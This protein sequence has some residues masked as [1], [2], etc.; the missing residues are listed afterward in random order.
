VRFLR[1]LGKVNGVHFGKKLALLIDDLGMFINQENERGVEIALTTCL[2][3]ERESCLRSK[4]EYRGIE[5]E[6]IRNIIPKIDF[7]VSSIWPGQPISILDSARSTWR[8]A[9]AP[10]DP[11]EGGVRPWRG[12]IEYLFSFD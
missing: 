3:A 2:G 4:D 7:M 9:I 11:W 10:V 6:T 1:F 12:Q 5:I 8:I